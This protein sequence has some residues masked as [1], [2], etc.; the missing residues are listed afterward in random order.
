MAIEE[1]RGS[2]KE[3]VRHPAID[4]IRSLCR[5]GSNLDPDDRTREAYRTNVHWTIG[6]LHPQFGHRRLSKRTSMLG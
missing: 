2:L 6:I 3:S 5:R 1:N 4:R